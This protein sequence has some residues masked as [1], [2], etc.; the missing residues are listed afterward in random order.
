MNMLNNENK[1]I[2]QQI[3]YSIAVMLISGSVIQSFLLENGI[4]ESRVALY[5]SII[6]I[7]Q[8]GC[9]LALSVVIDRIKKVIGICAFSMI[10]QLIIYAVLIFLCIFKSISIDLKYVLIFI[11]SICANIF[12][13]IYNIVSYKLPYHCIK[14][15]RFGFLTGILGIFTGIVCSGV[16]AIM[17]YFTNRF[18]YNIVMLVFFM[19]GALS[20]V[21]AFFATIMMQDIKP[22]LPEQQKTKVN[23]LK[24]KPFTFLIVPN[25]LRGFCTGIL[26]VSMTV[27]FSQGITNKSSGAVLS[28]L[29]QVSVILS[30]IIYTVLARKNIEGPIIA[31]ASLLLLI[32]MPFMFSGT[33]TTFYVVFFIANFFI[34][35]VNNAVPVAITKFVDYQ[36]IGAYS[37]WRM[38]THTLGIALS[39]AFLTPLL[40]LLGPTVLFMISGVLQ[41]ISG[42]SYLVCINKNRIEL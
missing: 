28:L 40:S 2:I 16:T 6:Q 15:S 23:L 31:I 12:Q 19:A 14:I 11:A 29:L 32:T 30:C 4:S 1:F 9:M 42:V 22:K 21:I 26:S 37:S 3:T 33:L 25:L 34:N 5:L 13:A 36:Y 27:G 38:L 18:D 20:F 7:V 8:V 24:Y 41:L 17:S 39:N 35:F 10:F